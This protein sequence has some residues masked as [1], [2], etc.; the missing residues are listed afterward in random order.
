MALELRLQEEQAKLASLNRE[1]LNGQNNEEENF[2]QRVLR[3]S[4]EEEKKERKKSDSR[5]LFL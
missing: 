2:E 1:H 3:L 5:Y 4:M